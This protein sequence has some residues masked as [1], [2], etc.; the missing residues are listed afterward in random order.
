RLAEEQVPGADPAAWFGIAPVS[1]DQPLWSGD[2]DVPLSP[3]TLEAASTCALRWALEAAGGRA[4]ESR[5][6]SLGTLVHEI[7]AALPAGTRDELERALDAR[8][9]ALGLPEGWVGQAQ[10]RRALSMIGHLAGYLGRGADVVGVEEKFEAR[11]GKVL[12]RG[13]VD[14]LERG[15]VG[16][17]GRPRLRVVDLKTGRSPVPKAEA[18]R[19]A[20]LGAY[21]AAVDAGAFDHLLTGAASGGAALVYV[22]TDNRACAEREQVSPTQDADPEWVTEMLDHVVDAVCR[23]TVTATTNSLCRTCPV[24]RSCPAQPEGRVVG[25]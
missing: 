7:A 5:E 23:S 6:Q 22:G 19:H 4:A 9:E 21:Q 10:R 12:L 20:Q 14:R 18:A 11:L 2:Q 13:T 15:P 25:Q 16:P 1:T 24:T 17:D 3:S 8:W